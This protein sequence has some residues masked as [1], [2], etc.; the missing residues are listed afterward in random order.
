M[1][2]TEMI[3]STSLHEALSLITENI[4]EDFFILLPHPQDG[5][6]G[7]DHVYILEAYAACFPSGFKPKDK[8]GKK[9]ADIHG[10]VPGYKEKLQTSMDRFFARLE[11]GR[12]VK[13]VNWSLT[14]DE[15]LYSNFD[16]GGTALKGNLE[17]LTLEDLDLKRVCSLKFILFVI[18]HFDLDIRAL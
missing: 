12:L 4:D 5:R 13:R 17:K 2:P 14:V 6:H 11:A 1:L 16:K 3:Q 7:P 15:E 8:I 18:S 9:L 10:P